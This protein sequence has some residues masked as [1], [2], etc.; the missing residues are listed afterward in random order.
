M[1]DNSCD[2]SDGQCSCKANISGE[3]CDTCSPGWWGF[4]HCQ[5]EID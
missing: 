5:G 2:Q 3:K 1:K 4:P